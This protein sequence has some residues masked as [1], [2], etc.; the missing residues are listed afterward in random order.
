MEVRVVTPEYF[1]TMGI[2]VKRGRGLDPSDSAESAPVAVI[3]EA[4]AQRYFPGEDPLGKRIA[5]GWRRPEGRP[6]AGGEVVGIVGDVKDQ[7]LAEAFPAEIYVPHAQLPVE[8]MDLVLRTSVSPES[9]LPSVQAAVHE[10]DPEL[11]VSRPR[12]LADIVARSLGEPRFYMTLLGAFAATALTLA[13]LGIFGVMSYMVVQRS[14]EIGT[15]IALGALPA[16]I[17]RATLR[18]A[19]LLAGSGVLVGLGGALVVSGLLRGLLFDLS[20]NDPATLV[21]VA[22][23][24]TAVALVAS[25][26][27]ARRAAEV[28]PICAL[29][30]E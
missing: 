7:G 16:D 17:L 13:A 29:R 19:L 10:L 11:P 25:W 5:L 20:P 6:K 26:L 15:R 18:R 4:A 1:R 23:L 22:L 8:S 9:I 3:T 21:T 12:T 24:L 30:S 28:D 2:P 27:P 14:R